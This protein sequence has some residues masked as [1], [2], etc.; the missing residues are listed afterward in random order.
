MTKY[1]SPTTNGFYDSEMFTPSDLPADA[2]E[3]SNEQWL[4]LLVAQ[5]SGKVIGPDDHGQPRESDPPPPSPESVA[6]ANRQMQKQLLALASAAK[7][8]LQ[9]AVDLGDAEPSEIALLTA[10]KQYSVAVNRID[11]TA[12][13]PVW[14][15]PP[16][17][18]S[19]AQVAT[20]A[21]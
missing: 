10:W 21:S 2:V 5:S 12:P 13:N 14:P 19:S 18:F 3:I 6:A 15:N 1:Y 20:Q 4:G 16:V 7:A 8:P 9:D 11:T 17:P